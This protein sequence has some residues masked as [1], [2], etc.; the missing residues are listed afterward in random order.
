MEYVVDAL[1]RNKQVYLK[2]IK[3]FYIFGFLAS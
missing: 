3:Y 1:N 2:K